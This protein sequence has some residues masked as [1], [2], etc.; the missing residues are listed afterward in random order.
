MEFFD[1]NEELYGS[2]HEFMR[3]HDGKTPEKVS[4]SPMLFQWLAEI[5]REEALL[6]GLNAKKLDLNHFPTEFGTHAIVIDEMLSDY[7]IIA[8]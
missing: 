4:V 8:E 6:K 3:V 5:R 7:E 1:A 2:I